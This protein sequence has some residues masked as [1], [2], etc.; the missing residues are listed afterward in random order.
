MHPCLPVTSATKKETDLMTII[1]RRCERVGFGR[2][3]VYFILSGA[4]EAGR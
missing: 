3:I 2:R 1:V 4:F